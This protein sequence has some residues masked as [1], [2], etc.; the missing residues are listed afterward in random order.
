MMRWIDNRGVGVKLTAS[1]V[2]FAAGLALVVA[3]ALMGM[4]AQMWRDREQRVR[5]LV[6]AA[7]SYANTIDAMVTEGKMTREQGRAL[8]LG[9]LQAGRYDAGSYFTAFLKDGT[10]VVHGG[11]IKAVGTNDIDKEDRPGHFYMRDAIRAIGNP[12]GGYY[13]VVATLPGGV[14]P[15]IYYAKFLPAWGFAVATGLVIDDVNAALTRQAQT[16][17]LYACPAILIGMAVGFLARRS[18]A[19][20]L[21]RLTECMGR[22]AKREPG[23]VVPGTQRRDEIGAMGRALSVFQDSMSEAEQLRASQARAGLDAELARKAALHR[24][25]EAFEAEVGGL[26]SEVATA[27]TEMKTTARSMTDTASRTERQATTVATASVAANGGI[28]MVAAAAEELSASISEISSQVARCSGMTAQ[29]VADA[30]RTDGLVRALADGADRIGQVVELISGIANQTNLLAL[31]ATIEAARAGDAGKGF[32]VVA[33][34]VKNL[35]TQTARATE[36]IGGQIAQ[37]QA[38]TTNAVEAIRAIAGAIEQVSGI[39]NDIASAVDQQ[40]AATSEIARNVQQAASAA[41]QVTA[42]IDEVSRSAHE[43]EGSA[44][45]VMTAAGDL[46]RRAET[47]S[48]AVAR[49]VVDVR[50]A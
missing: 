14:Y 36:D 35:A 34:E 38:A 18:I 48:V 19:G 6:E 27:S 17:A 49:F 22:L 39:A 47:L 13:D 2:V 33:S 23:V 15:K 8:V 9:L 16:I 21:R 41:G 30:Q 20:G 5:V 10:Y 28:Q 37:V 24:V 29:A 12:A 42:T 4:S 46:A 40:G 31:N 26:V 11:N 50:A 1:I 7:E 32:A 44:A 45:H 25:A 43:T 3:A